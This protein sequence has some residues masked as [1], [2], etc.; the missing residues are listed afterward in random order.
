[1]TISKVLNSCCDYSPIENPIK[2]A[3]HT[4]YLPSGCKTHLIRHDDKIEFLTINGKVKTSVFSNLEDIPN[5]FS[6]PEE[7]IQF[8]IEM[9]PIFDANGELKFT[10]TEKLHIWE[11]KYENP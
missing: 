9:D 10:V 6:S 3:I 7:F 8:M 11:R 4:W 2:N 5:N 1:M